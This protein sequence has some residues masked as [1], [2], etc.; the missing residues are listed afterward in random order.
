MSACE[1]AVHLLDSCPLSSAELDLKLMRGECKR[2][3]MDLLAERVEARMQ[4]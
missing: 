2:L 4:E 3:Q 1:R